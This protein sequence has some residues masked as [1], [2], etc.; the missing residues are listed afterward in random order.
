ML[1]DVSNLDDRDRNDQTTVT[2]IE[3]RWPPRRDVV[4]YRINAGRPRMP[5]AFADACF[6]R[7]V[8]AFLGPQNRDIDGAAEFFRKLP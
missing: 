3:S 8:N 4:L 1:A 5:G 2:R 6:P 7:I